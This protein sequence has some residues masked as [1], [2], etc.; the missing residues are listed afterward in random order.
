M[1]VH[2][3]LGEFDAGKDDWKSYIERAKQY[4]EAN[5]IEDAGKKRA[6][7]LSACGAATY[8]K[9]KDLLTPKAP[10]ETTFDEIVEK[11][12]KHLQPVPS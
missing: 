6:V 2:G 7:L 8:R 11:M 4:F 5:N 10:S 3:H 12:T 1:A 9:I